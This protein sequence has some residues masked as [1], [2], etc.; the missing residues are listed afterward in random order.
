M[1]F[2]ATSLYPSAM[3]DKNSVFPKIETVYAF[4]PHMNSVFVNEFNKQ[5]LNQNNKESAILRIKYYSPPDLIFQHLPVIEKVKNIEVNRL[6][7]GYII[8]TLTSVDIPEIVK[9]GRKA[10]QNHE[11]VI[12]QQNFKKSP[13]RKGIEKLFTLRQKYTDEKN[14]FMQGLVKLN[15]NNFYGVQKRTDNN[16]S[17]YGKSRT[18]IKTEFENVLNYWKLPN[19]NYIVKLR[20]DDGLDDDCDIK[21]ILPSRLGAFILSNIKRIINKFTR[22]KNGFYKINIYYSDCDSL[23]T[24]KRY[25]DVLDKANL[26]DKKLC[27]SKKLMIQVVSFMDYS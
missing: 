13:F 19:E 22:E 11:D 23:Y 8:D 7:N 26:V 15:L 17:F 5:T 1:D 20:K 14:D 25:W 24:E 3:W 10:I 12:Y 2:D 16:E 4:Q 27:H 21:N 18:W 6:R 9:I